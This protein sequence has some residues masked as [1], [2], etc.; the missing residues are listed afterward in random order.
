[1]KNRKIRTIQQRLQ[2]EKLRLQN[3]APAY[4]PPNFHPRVV[5][6]LDVEFE[7]SE[8]SL[9]EIGFK[10]ALPPPQTKRLKT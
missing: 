4:N 1:M 3:R 8:I 9:L 7:A 5:N 6:L 10:Y 2:S